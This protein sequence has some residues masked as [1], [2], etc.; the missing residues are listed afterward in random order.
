MRFKVVI[1][2]VA[3]SAGRVATLICK[4]EDSPYFCLVYPLFSRSKKI[5]P[6][7]RKSLSGLKAGSSF[8]RED[9]RASEFEISCYLANYVQR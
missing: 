9:Y 4:L 2:G 7:G 3:A 6:V 8:D 5:N 1:A